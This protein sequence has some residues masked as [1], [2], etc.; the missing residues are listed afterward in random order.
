MSMQSFSPAIKKKCWPLALLLGL[1]SQGVSTQAGAD[2]TMQEQ[3]RL[4]AALRQ[5]DTIEGLIEHQA[6]QPLEARTRFYF[7]YSR[8]STDLARIRAGIHDYLAPSRA[9]PRDVAQLSGDYR[10]TMVTPADAGLAP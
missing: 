4:A 9:Q 10:Q 5:L 1:S 8:L 6:D 3:E 2:G 7:D